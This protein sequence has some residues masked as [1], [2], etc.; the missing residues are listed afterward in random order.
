MGRQKRI[1][2]KIDRAFAGISDR[3][4]RYAAELTVGRA[5]DSLRPLV[6]RTYGYEERALGWAATDDVGDL[7]RGAFVFRVEAL[8]E[9]M[10]SVRRR[11]AGVAASTIKGVGYYE[12]NPEEPVSELRLEWRKSPKEPHWLAFEQHMFD[13]A[14]DLAYA[15]AQQEIIVML[16]HAGNE[17]VVYAS[18]KGFPAPGFGENLENFVEKEKRRRR[19]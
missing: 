14:E 13:L 3:V 6:G 19:R 5:V 15:F 2:H 1:L 4:K 18:P 16:H 11:Q 7:P 12:D 10:K 8:I 17:D 9:R